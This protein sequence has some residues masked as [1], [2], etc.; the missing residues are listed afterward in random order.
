MLLKD[1]SIQRAR[2][3]QTRTIMTPYKLIYLNIIIL[4]IYLT[5]LVNCQ[6]TSTINT[7][8]IKRRSFDHFPTTERTINFTETENDPEITVADLSA[9]F[10]NILKQNNGDGA[11]KVISDRIIDLLAKNNISASDFAKSKLV[12]E[13]YH[14]EIGASKIEN[15]ICKK[16]IVSAINGARTG[17]VWALKSKNLNLFN[18]YTHTNYEKKI[19][20]NLVLGKKAQ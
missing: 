9:N 18:F 11:N 17:Q 1:I 7:P 10:Q 12:S 5:T 14:L 15:Y 19:K 8:E 13:L 3:A 16:Q 2:A 20:N 6:D 4:L